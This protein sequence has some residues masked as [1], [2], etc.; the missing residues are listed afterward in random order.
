MA[1]NIDNAR[2]VVTDRAY[3]SEAYLVWRMSMSPVTEGYLHTA[4]KQRPEYPYFHW[5]NVVFR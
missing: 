4:Y 3:T 5:K 2:T 1:E